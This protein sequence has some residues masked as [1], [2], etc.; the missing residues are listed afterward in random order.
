MG[1]DD[2][3]TQLKEIAALAEESKTLLGTGENH[4]DDDASSTDCSPDSP[5]GLPGFS[6]RI[7][8]EIDH[9]ARL[10]MKLLPSLQHFIEFRRR[11]GDKTAS[12][13]NHFTASHAASAYIDIVREK[14]PEAKSDLVEGLGEANWEC[15]LRIRERLEDL[16]QNAEARQVFVTAKSVFRPISMFQD[17]ALGS[18]IRKPSDY[19]A[20]AVSHS[21][22]R[23][24]AT[25]GGKGS[26]RVPETPRE[27]ELGI[28]FPCAICGDILDDITNRYQWKIH[29]FSDLEAYI[30]TFADCQYSLATFPNREL[31]AAHEFSVHR[32]AKVWTCAEC[33]IDFT[34]EEYC[35]I[36]YENQQ[37]VTYLG[38]D[39]QVAV[40]ASG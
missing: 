8:E 7:L 14:F 9:H 31:W 36:H 23:T 40:L 33:G 15:H 26:L 28:P 6:E 32:T 25:E 37:H 10:L 1:K 3:G 4:S 22:F 17:S 35:R 29:V 24:S 18:S 12:K 19:A 20:S 39:V 5:G 34:T 13:E 38:A 11:E 21:S 30:C 16:K 27:M 2:I